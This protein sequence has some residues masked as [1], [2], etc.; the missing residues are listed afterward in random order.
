M[1]NTLSIMRIRRVLFTVYSQ[2]DCWRA[3]MGICELG[4]RS[5]FNYLGPELPAKQYKH[6][7][8]YAII[9]NTAAVEAIYMPLDRVVVSNYY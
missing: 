8:I 6:N 4:R 7:G 3:V 2:L 5:D 1:R 9:P